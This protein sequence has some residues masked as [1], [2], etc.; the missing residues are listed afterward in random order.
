MP[1]TVAELLRVILEP[2]LEG[3]VPPGLVFDDGPIE[4]VLYGGATDPSPPTAQAGLSSPRP[5]GS[6]ALGA[7]RSLLS[8]AP[9]Q[10]EL[11]RRQAN[12]GQVLEL[13]EGAWWAA[14]S[15]QDAA[16][17]VAVG[18][19]LA[20]GYEAEGR[21]GE[22]G[23][24]WAALS[25]LERTRCDGD[26]GLCDLFASAAV[27]HPFAFW[28][29]GHWRPAASRFA[30]VAA[31][32]RA[33]SPDDD[34]PAGA[35]PTGPEPASPALAA[36]AQAN[37][38]RL[39]ASL[40][41]GGRSSEAE[42]L[43]RKAAA[44]AVLEVV[45]GAEHPCTATAANMVLRF[46]HERGHYADAVIL[47]RRALAIREPVLGPRHSL[48]AESLN[49]LGAALAFLGPTEEAEVTLCRSAEANPNTSSPLWWLAKVY[50][51][52]AGPG[53]REREL[54]VLQRYMRVGPAPHRVAEAR[55]R[56]EELDAQ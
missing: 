19:P 2:P 48:V 11:L 40:R 54:D 20:L 3:G 27:Y 6:E 21:S 22:G 41:E 53:D 12:S 7:L 13:L 34:P 14:Q 30:A 44:F 29:E 50:R 46:L 4:E 26:E 16:L 17:A 10:I 36:M 8:R 55:R 45:A 47:A 15:R 35:V 23:R 43:F 9:E 18:L 42:D 49:N 25:D 39:T 24:I 37:L 31:A 52:R 38:G 51:D 28:R 32:L 1:E 33:L 5:L 56:L